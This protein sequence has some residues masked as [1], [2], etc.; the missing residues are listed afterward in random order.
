ML[1]SALDGFDTAG[2]VAIGQRLAENLGLRIGDKLKIL[3]AN[4]AQTLSA[5]PR[6]QGLSGHRD[7]SD[8][9][10]GVRH[11]FV[12]GLARAQGFFKRTIRQASSRFSWAGR[13]NSTRSRARSTGR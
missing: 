7:L 1:N 6:A 8:R 4:G 3:I 5:S 12:Y 13:R 2:G 10:G 9:H 11:L